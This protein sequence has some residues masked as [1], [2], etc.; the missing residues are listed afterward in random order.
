MLKSEKYEYGSMWTFN[1]FWNRVSHMS[2]NVWLKFFLLWPL[3]ACGAMMM[4]VF[5]LCGGF[6]FTMGK[7]KYRQQQA[8]IWRHRE[9]ME[10]VKSK[11]K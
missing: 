7:K 9:M 10:A 6:L 4:L 2:D 5:T 11:S 3:A 8:E 1:G